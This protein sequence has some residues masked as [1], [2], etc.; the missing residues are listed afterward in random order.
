MSGRVGWLVLIDASFWWGG[1]QRAKSN[2]GVV[3]ADVFLDIVGLEEWNDRGRCRRE[4]AGNVFR[5]P[6][7]NILFSQFASFMCLRQIIS[8]PALEKLHSLCQGRYANVY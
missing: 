1:Y 2:D 8:P 3:F 5:L 7:K 6:R 4:V